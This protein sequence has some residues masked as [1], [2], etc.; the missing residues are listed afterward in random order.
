M[1]ESPFN[2]VVGLKVCKFIKKRLQHRCFPVKIAKFLRTAFL[3]RT[4][5]AAADISSSTLRRLK[6]YLDLWAV[7]VLGYLD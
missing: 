2:K 7:L 1:L 3:Y 6:I 4:P 5:P